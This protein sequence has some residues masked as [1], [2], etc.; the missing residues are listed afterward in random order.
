MKTTLHIGRFLALI[1]EG[2]WEYAERVNATGAAII[3]AVTDQQKLLLVEQYR[4]PVHSRTIELPAGIIG[5]EP[6]ASNEPF[7]DAAKRELLEET[8]YQAERV[9]VLT[10]GPASSGLTSETVSLFLATGLRRVGAGGGI[11]HEE[12]TVHEVPLNEVHGWLAEKA[13]TGA[14]VDPKIYAGLY[15]VLHR[16]K[17]VPPM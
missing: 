14:L 7:E 16:A 17:G 11:E 8:G 6:G 5:D 10:H 9:E 1:K 15:F 4:I 3:V 2:H 12:I 13:R